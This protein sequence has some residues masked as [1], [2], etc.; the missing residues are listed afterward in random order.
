MNR[1]HSLSFLLAFA[2]PFAGL[3]LSAAPAL[4]QSAPPAAAAPASAPVA[5]DGRVQ[6][7]ALSP[8]G[9]VVAVILQDGTAVHVPPRSAAASLKPGDA[10]HI[11]GQATQTPTGVVITRAIVQQ[12]GRVVADGSKAH[13]RGQKANRGQ[14][15]DPEA[16][17]TRPRERLAQVSASGRVTQVISNPMGKAHALLLDDGTTATGFGLEKLGL[18]PGDRVQ[19]NGRGG[20]YSLGKALRIQAITLP[21]GETRTLAR[22][23][24]KPRGRAMK[25]QPA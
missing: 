18:K 16:R 8:R 10:V 6:R 20:T 13:P 5:R 4:A 25:R 11:E 24:H 14:G 1:R 23:N 7:F 12:Q 15:R 21:N 17:K 3:S 22:P 9:D 19:M 2:I